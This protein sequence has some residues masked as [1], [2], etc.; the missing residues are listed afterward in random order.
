MNA[1]A[2]IAPAAK[3]T[4]LSLDGSTTV[5]V[6]HA[7]HPEAVRSFDTDRL[8]RH[9]LIESLFRPD[10]VTLT[11]SHIDR[12]V[13]GGAMPVSTALPLQALKPIGSDKF[14]RRRE[15]GLLNVG[16]AGWVTVDGK[17]FEIAKL[18]ALYV[19][20]GAEDIRFQSVDSSQ[21]AKFYLMSTPAHASHETRKIA[22]A[23]ARKIPLGARETANVR[24]IYQVIHPEVCKSCQLVMGFTV[25]EPGSVWNTMP[26][27]LHDRRC[28]IYF[29]FDLQPET[30]VFHFM[31]EPAETRHLLVANEQAVLSPSWSLHS[32]VGTSNYTFVWAMAGDNQDFADMDALAM[33]DLR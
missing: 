23:D 5:E 24:T 11:Y 13:V 2:T 14:L 15:L 25:L 8:R 27:H 26:S 29:Y 20:M 4:F 33:S 30:R 1:P 18:D 32:G 12:F 31:G 17:S 19:A 10:A 3:D 28:E 22:I 21:P 16:G 6:R 9:F 7:S